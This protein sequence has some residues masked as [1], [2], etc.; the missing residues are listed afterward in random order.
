MYDS[1]NVP[2]TAIQSAS[3]L[4]RSKSYDT[5]LNSLADS[6][7]Y[8]GMFST[9]NPDSLSK[10]DEPAKITVT[11]FA[12]T[13]S[14][15]RSRLN[16]Y[17]HVRPSSQ[18][19]NSSTNLNNNDTNKNN[20][21]ESQDSNNRN[22]SLQ[23]PNG[24]NNLPLIIFRAKV[25]RKTYWECKK[26]G[27]NYRLTFKFI[28]GERKLVKAILE[29]HGFREVHP[30][31]SEFNIIWSGNNLKSY[32]FRGL[33][34]N[35]KVNHFP[36][37]C[38]LTRKDR[39]YK[40]IQRM[41]KDKG[42]KAFN[43]VPTTFVLPYE[44]D[45]FYST[46]YK[47]KGIWIVKPVCLSRGRGI[48]LIS[49]PDQ[50]PLDDNLVVSKYLSNPL[51]IEGFKFDLRLYVAVTSFDPLIFYL[52][53]EGLTRFATIKYDQ[54]V[55]NIRNT[56]MHLTNY[57]L[58][59]KNEKYVKC[60][61]PEV[62]NYGNKWSMSALLRYL[63][64]QGKDT[65][66]LMMNIEEVLIKTLLSVESPMASAARMFMPH[67]GNCFELFGFDILVDEFFKPWVLEVNL[68]PSLDCDALLDIKIKSNMLADLFT[69]TGIHCQNPTFFSNRS[70]Q[71]NVKT[72][73]DPKIKVRPHSAN[74]GGNGFKA[75]QNQIKETSDA[76]YDG[77]SQTEQIILKTSVEENQR[78]NG[79]L[80]IFP[81]SDTWEF[82]S[83]YLETRSTSYNMM[84]HKKLFPRRWQ[85]GSAPKKAAQTRVKALEGSYEMYR[86]NNYSSQETSGAS[87]Y[88]ALDRY[89]RYERKL[90]DQVKPNEETLKK[91]STQPFHIKTTQVQRSNFSI[92]PNGDRN[93]E[94]D[95]SLSS[96]MLNEEDYLSDSTNDNYKNKNDYKN[97]NKSLPNINKSRPVTANYSV[98]NYKTNLKKNSKNEYNNK[99]D[100]DDSDSEDNDSDTNN[101]DNNLSGLNRK[102]SHINYD[103]KT[104][105]T[106]IDQGYYLSR[107]QVRNAFALYLFKIQMRLQ[108]ESQTKDESNVQQMDLVLRF[109]KKAAPNLSQE[110]KVYVPSK[111]LPLSEQK[112][113]LSKQ[114]HDFLHVYKKDTEQIRIETGLQM[115]NE[116]KKNK[117]K[118]IDDK[119][120]QSLL[121]KCS[122]ADLEEIMSSY[123]K[124][125]HDSSV[126]LGSKNNKN[127]NNDPGS[128]NNNNN[129]PNSLIE[130]K[131]NLGSKNEE[132]EQIEK[133][134]DDN[135][136]KK[137]ND[138]ENGSQLSCDSRSEFSKSSDSEGHSRSRSRSSSSIES[139]SKIQN[140]KKQLNNSNILKEKRI[141]N[142]SRQKS[143]LTSNIKNSSN[144]LS[145]FESSSRA[146][147]E[148][149]KLPKTADY[150]S[151]ISNIYLSSNSKQ[152]KSKPK[153]NANKILNNR[154]NTIHSSSS[155][156]NLI[157][158]NKLAPLAINSQIS[159]NSG[160]NS[161]YSPM[162]T[163]SKDSQ[164]I[165][166]LN[167]LKQSSN[168][169]TQKNSLITT[170]NSNNNNNTKSA[171]NSSRSFLSNS[172]LLN[173]LDDASI[174]SMGLKNLQL[175]QQERLYS[176]A[177]SFRI[178]S[179]LNDDEHNKPKPPN[180]LASIKTTK[181]STQNSIKS[182]QHDDDIK[183]VTSSSK[184]SYTMSAKNGTNLREFLVDPS[185]TTTNESIGLAVN[186]KNLSLIQ[187]LEQQKEK[188]NK[189]LEKS[190]AKH[191]QMMLDNQLITNKK[192]NTNDNLNLYFST[193]KN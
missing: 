193:V 115:E 89:N 49:H 17:G 146:L 118:L 64:S 31:S 176:A 148:K 39:L 99:S 139:N 57:S 6:P 44:I 54:N 74:M 144:R 40:N 185:E 104:V 46:F 189:L 147:R 183:H 111:K 15:N 45:D 137:K 168:I 91:L 184:S 165:S 177:K 124:N 29:G 114:L 80:R 1:E 21:N 71:K 119:C 182:N 126:F 34:E 172:Q 48:Y 93:K 30:N 103:L 60:N 38:E 190:R 150:K 14:D 26:I 192:Q 78:A 36:R 3:L 128:N 12:P 97:M 43:I 159:F 109:I 154:P 123:M 51:L 138:D 174:L 65:F 84:L 186:K 82:Y 153:S 86:I 158:I 58:N 136:I 69:L 98:P 131:F 37:S 4:L 187:K 149:P 53:E 108:S 41:Q 175:K 122:E 179:S 2:S 166:P 160:Q 56:C 22:L 132:K 145:H 87:L 55:R 32:L 59:K 170:N 164:P 88:E 68:S 178:V 188:T 35:Q 130:F 70:R 33:Q 8:S 7:I 101:Q 191:N 133:V 16:Y 120:F 161:F 63:S 163:S 10:T 142:K 140:R 62:E 155:N 11:S 157:P 24:K 125:S 85:N 110:F 23:W 25:L 52:Y 167:P 18:A 121:Y 66:T 96:E 90:N 169:Y 129:E 77:L 9:Y 127:Q 67:R 102:D 105:L 106:Y 94:K 135:G 116:R 47:E 156:N 72:K 42:H 20:K 100:E 181:N 112:R 162:S 75:N 143:F 61:D 113:M 73:N 152:V 76:L 83:Q 13:P 151:I 180:Q 50:I 171:L 141:S 117:N 95:A 92:F 134:K 19:L 27:E 28:H 107:I 81:T 173:G 79:W 5:K